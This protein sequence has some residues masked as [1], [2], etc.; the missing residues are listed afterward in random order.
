MSPQSNHIWEHHD[1]YIPTTLHQSL[2]SSFKDSAKRDTKT[3]THTHTL[4]LK[5]I[6]YFAV[7]G[8]QI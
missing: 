1:T 4:Q 3:H 5:T 6:P 8:S 7:M 2:I